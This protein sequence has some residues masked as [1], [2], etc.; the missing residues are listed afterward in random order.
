MFGWLGQD[1]QVWTPYV[2]P[3]GKYGFN[4]YDISPYAYS[5]VASWNPNA[6]GNAGPGTPAP[7]PSPPLT[8]LVPC[9]DAY[10]AKYK[11]RFGYPPS[12]CRPRVNLPNPPIVPICQAGMQLINGRCMP[13]MVEPPHVPVPVGPVASTPARRHRR[14]QPRMAFQS[15]E[16]CP[17]RGYVSRQIPGVAEYQNFRCT[18]G[19][20]VRIDPGLAAVG[21]QGAY[22]R[23]A[24]QGLGESGLNGGNTFWDLGD[25]S[26][27]A[28]GG[29]TTPTWLLAA[30]LM[31][32][33]VAL[34]S[35]GRRRR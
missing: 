31:I 15:N 12:F 23:A 10:I 18:P 35:K 6:Q 14:R 7:V 5:V 29:D 27:D 3:G 24:A 16:L 9:T 1:P 8:S 25:V 20:P 26:I 19:R 22:Q 11:S 13:V 2:D 28:A 4:T 32:G 33:F 21:A 34:S 17:I 30:V